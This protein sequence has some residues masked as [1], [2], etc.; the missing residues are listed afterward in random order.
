[1]VVKIEAKPPVDPKFDATVASSVVKFTQQA[2]VDAE[3]FLEIAG[4]F[5]IETAGE[6]ESAMAER[7]KAKE[8]WDRLEARRTAITGPLNAATKS[9]NDLFRAPLDLFKRVWE[10]IDTNAKPYLFAVREQ[11]RKEE[12]ARQEP[13]RK[14]HAR[15]EKAEAA[16]NETRV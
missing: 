4:A 5:P 9:V 12:E 8:E 1:M 6:Y 7:R 13:L 11:Q 3:Q 15:E 2:T 14:L 16:G 10:T